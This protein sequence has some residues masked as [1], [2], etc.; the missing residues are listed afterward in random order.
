M[1][2][3]ILVCDYGDGRPA[4]EQITVRVGG[5]SLIIDLCQQHLRELTANAR[6]PKRGRKPK[7]VTAAI[8]N[9]RRRGGAKSIS[10]KKT[11][12]KA[13]TTKTGS[14]KRRT[15]KRRKP[16]RAKG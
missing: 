6:A 1:E 5:R 8:S 4:A 11:T 14:R 7:A 12:R 9:G 3:V 2:S 10:S 15:T 13:A 16:V